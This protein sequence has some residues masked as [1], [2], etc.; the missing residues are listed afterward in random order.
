M[1]EEDD[2]GVPRCVVDFH[3]KSLL[4]DTVAGSAAAARAH[5]LAQ[6]MSTLSTSLPVSSGSS[7]FVRVD[8]ERLDVM[9]VRVHCVSLEL[10]HLLRI[11]GYSFF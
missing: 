8:E 1:V 5:R 7:V 10:S 11:E 2:E 3:Y 4:H 9:K 6:E